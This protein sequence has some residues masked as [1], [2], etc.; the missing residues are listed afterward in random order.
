M[1]FIRFRFNSPGKAEL[2]SSPYG[3]VADVHLNSRRVKINTNIKIK[4][5]HFNPVRPS[6]AQ[7]G[8]S[9]A[10]ALRTFQI[11][12]EKITEAINYYN[13]G[14]LSQFDS[15]AD[16]I[17]H[18]LQNGINLENNL[19][20]M[21]EEFLNYKKGEKLASR[22]KSGY[23]KVGV[24]IKSIIADNPKERF[25]VFHLDYRFFQAYTK[26]AIKEDWV[27]STYN[28]Y[29]GVIKIWLNWVKKKYSK[30]EF[31]DY[32]KEV[33]ELNEPDN[34]FFLT[35]EEITHLSEFT[36]NKQAKNDARDMFIFQYLIGARDSDIRP[37]A[38]SLHYI[39]EERKWLTI[40]SK[41]QTEVIDIPLPEK[42]MQIYYR[43]KEAGK[44]PLSSNQKRNKLLKTLILNAKMD[45]EYTEKT[46]KVSDDDVVI[47]KKKLSDGITTHWARSSFVTHMTNNG[48]PNHVIS[49]FTGQSD[50][51]I[52]KYQGKDVATM[53]SRVTDHLNG[54]F[55]NDLNKSPE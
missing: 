30:R 54:L 6:I 17:E 35:K 32:Y 27:S 1:A 52:K 12:H 42:A 31:D 46:L 26:Y 45:R 48:V 51:T 13:D 21:Y 40:P 47:A 22:T 18:Y 15:A 23:N 4:F 16:A 33:P 20:E 50:R 53:I 39:D 29:L 24:I 55:L 2:S 5:K 41:K 8:I 19:W 36:F 7:E 9:R 25:D 37:L 11:T 14:L 44:F 10:E 3:V 34:I 49:L 43:F 38:K 28:K